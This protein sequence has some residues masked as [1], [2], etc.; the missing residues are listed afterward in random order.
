MTQ[1]AMLIG[2]D[3]DYAEPLYWVLGNFLY[4]LAMSHAQRAA[5]I[6]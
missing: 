1:G 4:T 6:D 5:K 3:R 2:L